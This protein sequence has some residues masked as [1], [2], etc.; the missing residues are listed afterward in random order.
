MN[1]KTQKYVVVTLFIVV[2]ALIVI[3]LCQYRESPSSKA[4]THNI[5]MMEE[6]LSSN[7]FVRHGDAWELPDHRA[8]N[9]S[10]TNS[11]SN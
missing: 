5:Q 7:G 11:N 9:I 4:A 3:H 1:T 2:L 8:T 6:T 10:G